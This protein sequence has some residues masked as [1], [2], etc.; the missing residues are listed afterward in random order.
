MAVFLKTKKSILSLMVQIDFSAR[1]E[2]SYRYHNFW[3][4]HLHSTLFEVISE[5]NENSQI[6]TA[7]LLTLL[8]PKWFSQL[9]IN[10]HSDPRG[11]DSFFTAGDFAKCRAVEIWG[12]ECPYTESK[13]EI[14]HIFPHSKGGSTSND[15]AMYLCYE[16]NRA[17]SADVHLLPW[18]TFNE[19]NWIKIRLEHLFKKA[20]AFSSETLYFPKSQLKR[21]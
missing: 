3:A 19:K 17:K 7:E 2:A 13:I 20:Q 5:I 12:Y 1:L 8:H 6:G 14:D 9:G 21:I 15:N 4:N 11:N 10:P 18:E 16:H